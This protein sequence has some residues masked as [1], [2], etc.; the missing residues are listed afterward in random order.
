MQKVTDDES[1]DYL[2]KRLINVDSEGSSLCLVER[3]KIN[4]D[5]AKRLQYAALSYCWGPREHAKYQSKTTS[6][7]LNHHL[8]RLDFDALPPVLK[9]AIKV[10]RSL[11][12]PYLWVDSL[13]ILQDQKLDWQ[14]QCS[15]MKDIY[16]KARV[17]IIA[18]SS[19]SCKE[20][21]LNPRRHGLRFP[22]QSARRPGI[23]GSFMMYF[24]HVSILGE[25][26]SNFA[27]GGSFSGDLHCNQWARRGW[28]FQ[29]YHMAGARILFGKTGVYFLRDNIVASKA[30]DTYVIYN[31]PKFVPSVQSNDELHRAWEEVMIHYSRFTTSSFTDPTD[32]LPALSGLARLFGEVLKVDYIAGHWVDRLHLSMVWRHQDD[33]SRHIPALSELTK[34]RSQK[35]YLIPSWSSFTSGILDVLFWQRYD[36]CRSEVTILDVHKE[37]VGEDP[38]GALNDAYLTLEGYVLDLASLSW[39]EWPERLKG[40]VSGRTV[41]RDWMEEDEDRIDE[42]EIWFEEYGFDPEVPREV[43][44]TIYDKVRSNGFNI[45]REYFMRLDFRVEPGD[46]SLLGEIRGTLDQLISRA[47]LLLL[48]SEDVYSKYEF[49]G[50]L[51]AGYGLVLV[52]WEGAPER[53]FLRVG[54][55][56]PCSD[57]MEDSDD[58]PCLKRLM[59]KEKIKIY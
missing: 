31:A 14:E 34:R 22:Y 29:E 57:V 30:W 33:D 52:P 2:P 18:A 59:K 32:L 50:V 10:T 40:S 49:P 43:C 36:R 48:G 41:K 7:N 27:F 42:D 13:C 37:L 15:Q 4:A 51:K 26:P 56:Q 11:S 46:R 39:S 3:S 54:I 17:T 23:N 55:F 47:T 58:L 24:S 28:T 16:G 5:S 44:F 12:I 38:Y 8:E 35:P 6:K 9:D 20:G 25:S 45:R 53:S 19:T 1:A 21:F